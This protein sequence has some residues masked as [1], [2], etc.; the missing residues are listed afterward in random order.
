MLRGYR[1]CRTRYTDA[2]K[3]LRESDEDTAAVEFNL[4]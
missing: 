1:A 2:T 4:E 3:M